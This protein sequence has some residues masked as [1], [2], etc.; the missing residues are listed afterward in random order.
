[1]ASSGSTLTRGIYG[2][3]LRIAAEFDDSGGCVFTAKM[4]KMWG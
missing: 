1:M 2:S 4:S 3:D